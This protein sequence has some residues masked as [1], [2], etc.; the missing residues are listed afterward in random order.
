VLILAAALSGAIVFVTNWLALIPWRRRKDR[1]W[2]ERARVYYPV[3]VAAGSNLW[4]L[5]AVLT[6]TALLL[7]PEGSPHWAL[8]FLVTVIGAVA[9]T[10]PMDL[11]VF[12]RI[13]FNEL[14]RQA[15]MSWVIRF[16]MWFVFLG[17]IVLM[18]EKF[19]AWTL[20]IA[21]AVVVLCVVWNHDGWLW[22]GRKLGLFLP[23]PDRLQ[24]IVGKTAAAMNVS[25]REICLMRSFLALAYAMPATRRLLFSERLLQ[26]LSD[27][28][29]EAI[30]AHELAHLSEGWRQYQ[31]YVIWLM[32]LPWI[33]FRPT[34]HAFELAGFLLLLAL[35]LLA[36]LLFQ[37]V[38]RKLEVRAD[39]IA[40]SNEPDPGTY[41][42]ALLRLYEDNLLPAVD[43]KNRATHPH[44][45]DRLLACG[46]TPDF[47]RPAPP[48]PMSLHGLI[49][50]VALGALAAILVIRLTG[51]TFL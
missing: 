18:P 23:P 40:Q 6:M 19:N 13:R 36:P 47:P 8:M 39:R 15:A 32:F 2:T 9:G 50:S 31:R 25:V 42:R 20:V 45:Y 49:F 24:T 48:R 1:H 51:R 44:L 22:V 10:L 41:A 28:E 17:A 4:V 26:L 11:E 37:R 30:S 29:L 33:F 27:D 7:W 35:T 38:S 46:V 16:L 43:A 21:A 12:P 5:P 3:R 14:L 34:V